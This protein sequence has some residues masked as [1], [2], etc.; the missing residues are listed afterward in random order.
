MPCGINRRGAKKTTG[1]EREIAETGLSITY[2]AIFFADYAE[3][4]AGF[5]AR[6]K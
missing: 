6:M 2:S 5:T 1:Y 4:L 3:K